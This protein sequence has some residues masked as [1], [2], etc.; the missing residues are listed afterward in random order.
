MRIGLSGTEGTGKTFLAEKVSQR[1][2][3]PLIPEF[4]R[5]VTESLG[6]STPRDL[7]VDVMYSIQSR[8]LEKKLEE[9]DKHP[10][11]I[12]DRTTADNLAYYLRW[13]CDGTGQT[14]DEAYV[15]TCLKNLKTYDKIFLMPW[16]SIPAEKDGFRSTNKYYRYEI[17][18]LILGIFTDQDIPY[19][20]LM[21]TDLEKRIDRIGE[22]YGY[23]L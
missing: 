10:T 18:C 3:I 23:H 7:P 20:T 22:C 15:S 5:D 4:V 14:F 1:F 8:V 9:E 13:C 11:F 17:H 21:E 16:D 12:A 19:E 6:I 2:N